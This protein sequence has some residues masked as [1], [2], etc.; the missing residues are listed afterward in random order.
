MRWLVLLA[1]LFA[2]GYATKTSTEFSRRVVLTWAFITPVPLIFV[3]LVFN[4]FVRRF[5]LAP[6][7]CA[8]AVVAGYNDVSLALGERI[9]R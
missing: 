6:A 5:M 2:I 4:E 3:S 9:Q 7:T 8:S 1:L